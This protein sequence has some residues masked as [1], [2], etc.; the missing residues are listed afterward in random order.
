MI[1]FSRRGLDTGGNIHGVG[2]NVLYGGGNVFR[3]EAASKNNTVSG[4]S[5]TSQIPVSGNAGAAILAW[6]RLRRVQEKSEGLWI[7]VKIG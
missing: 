2:A 6:L 4:D 3:V 7:L 5:A 1:L